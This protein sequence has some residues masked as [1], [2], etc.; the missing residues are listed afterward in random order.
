MMILAMRDPRQRVHERH[1]LVVVGEVE[2]LDDRL[3]GDLQPGK[4]ATCAASSSA[5]SRGA[6]GR[7]CM[8][9]S[10]RVRRGRVCA[11]GHG[12]NV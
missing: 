8:A 5:P 7:Q 4:V 3:A 10:A 12:L 6:P 1:R 9:A 11:I 2:F